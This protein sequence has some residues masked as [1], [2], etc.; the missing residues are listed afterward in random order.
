MNA[1][2]LDGCEIWDDE[3]SYALL[4][5]TEDE[6][7][8]LEFSQVS[9]SRSAGSDLPHYAAASKSQLSS[10]SVG[11]DLPH[12]IKFPHPC[13]LVHL[14]GMQNESFEI[15]QQVRARY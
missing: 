5:S 12:L 6:P 3:Q 10:R 11:S 9:S 8:L 2:G 15:K 14:L 13:P 7:A 1:I 4:F